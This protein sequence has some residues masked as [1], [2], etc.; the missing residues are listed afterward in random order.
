MGEV[1]G[2]EEGHPVEVH[3]A[4]IKMIKTAYENVAST[5]PQVS[6][7]VNPCVQFNTRE[8]YFRDEE[9]VEQVKDLYIKQNGE[10][11]RVVASI[12]QDNEIQPLN[13]CKNF[14]KELEKNLTIMDELNGANLTVHL[15]I[16]AENQMEEVIN[17]LTSNKML[18]LLEK[19]KH[20]DPLSIDLENNHHSSFF[21]NL[22]NC[23]FFLGKL[24]ERLA[25][26]EKE[27]Y[28]RFFNICLDTGH[29]LIDA[30]HENYPKQEMLD[31]FL[32][33]HREKIKTIHLHA[34]DGSRDQHLLLGQYPGEN[35]AISLSNLNL[36][37]LK[38]HNAI[39]QNSLAKSQLWD[40]QDWIVVCELA[41]PYTI[42]ELTR[43][44]EKLCEN[45]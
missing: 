28:Y 8:F 31:R 22:N 4:L 3:K 44:F 29:Y 17:I 6:D 11:H 39:I 27:E 13:R 5:F 18:N 45:L 33:K 2:L 25:Q 40:L 41:N 43:A 23:S 34:N 12:H 19:F 24:R 36:P 37:R 35:S 32:E 21:G 42:E 30:H 20:L 15:P 10:K 14:Y 9:I 7:T 1:L 16:S 38:E 26:R